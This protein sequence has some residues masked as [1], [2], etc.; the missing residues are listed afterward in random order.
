[1]LAHHSKK[2]SIH[3]LV[4]RATGCTPA[5]IA[6]TRHFNPRPREEG[7]GVSRPLAAHPADFNPRPREEGDSRLH[8][9]LEFFSC[10]SIH[11]LV[12]RATVCAQAFAIFIKENFNPRPRE[13][14]DQ[15]LHSLSA[16]N[17]YFNPRPREEGDLSLSS[18]SNDTK[19]FQ[20]TPS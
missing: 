14:G 12:K 1:M 15:I 2:I 17:G 16:V 5:P 9:G 11:A 19:V 20:S 4:K 3:A 18:S 6:D 13:E 7:D 8:R 10:I